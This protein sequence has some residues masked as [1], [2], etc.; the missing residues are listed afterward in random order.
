MSEDLKNSTEQLGRVPCDKSTCAATA[1]DACARAGTESSERR[2]ASH[3]DAS[4]AF[5]SGKP[6]FVFFLKMICSKQDVKVS[7]HMDVLAFA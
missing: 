5:S 7:Q 2:A 3:N 1:I 4:L 6:K